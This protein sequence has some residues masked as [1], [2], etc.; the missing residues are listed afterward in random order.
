MKFQRKYLVVGGAILAIAAG[1]TGAAF[2]TGTVG[3]DDGNEK[4]TGPAADQATAA[5]LKIT[6]GGTA[7]SVERDSENGATY[8]VEVTKPDGNTVDV[9]LDQNYD[10]VVS[11]ATTRRLTRTSARS[12]QRPRRSPRPSSCMSERFP[13]GRHGAAYAC[14]RGG[15]A[16]HRRV[17]DRAR[18]VLLARSRE[19][20]AARRAGRDR[21]LRGR[22]DDLPRGIRPARRDVGG[23]HRGRRAA[24]RAAGC[25]T[26]SSEGEPFGHPWML[27]GLPTGW[28]A[29]AR[30]DSLCYRLAAAEVIPLL[31]DPAG[32]R[33]M[34]RSL[35]DRPRPGGPPTERADGDRHRRWRGPRPDPQAPGGLQAR[36]A[37]EPGGGA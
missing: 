2:A 8:E 26:C 32:L 27:S 35:M 19:A 7:N 15:H 13:R 25:S 22:Q 4:I 21:V 31:S 20:R 5:A 33:S 30:E 34:A 10:L 12:V 1:G 29:R 24:S 9:R 11:R 16:R 23:S 17:P 18:S 14:A 36:R 37:T 3:G 28:E 6:N